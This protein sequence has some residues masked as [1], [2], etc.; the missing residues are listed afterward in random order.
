MIIADTDVLIDFLRGKQP[1]ADRVAIELETRSFGTTAVSA[2]ELRSGARSERQRAA[3][4]VLLE[5]MTILALG[6]HEAELAANLRIELESRGEGIGMADYLIAGTCLSRKAM[7]LTKNR[8][9][10]GR[11][12]G[13]SL[14]TLQST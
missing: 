9:H 1:A 14:A 12:T 11:V 7:L 5:A 13:L 4:T 3:I 6:S 2:F 10:F 8:K